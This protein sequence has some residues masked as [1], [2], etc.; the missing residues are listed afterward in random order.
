MG[1]FDM[2]NCLEQYLDNLVDTF[3]GAIKKRPIAF[4]VNN[5][6]RSSPGYPTRSCNFVP[7]E[8]N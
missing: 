7:K 2:L 4:Q 3:N 8:D 5:D 1:A 6:T